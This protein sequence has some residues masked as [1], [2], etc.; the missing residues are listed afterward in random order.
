MAGVPT[1]LGL[2]AAALHAP[3]PDRPIARPEPVTS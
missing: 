3:I 1:P 2:I